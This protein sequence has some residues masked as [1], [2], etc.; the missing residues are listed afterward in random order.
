MH[1][2]DVLYI[3]CLF[4]HILSHGSCIHFGGHFVLAVCTM[5]YL[6]TYVHLYLA[7]FSPAQRPKS[8]ARVV[9]TWQRDS[10]C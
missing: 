10:A 2:A 8:E 7:H 5:M 6:R 9:A 1:A 3:D 4:Y